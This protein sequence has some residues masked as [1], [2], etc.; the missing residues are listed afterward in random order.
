VL[1]ILCVVVLLLSSSYA[2]MTDY[3]Q[4]EDAIVFKTGNLE[5]TILNGEETFNLINLNNKLPESDQSGL[6]TATA[7]PITLKNTGSITIGTYDVKLVA[8]TGTENISTLSEEYI[9]FSVSEDNVTYSSPNTLIENENIIFTGNDL[10][11]DQTK[12]IYVKLWLSQ[13][14]NSTIFQQQYYGSIKIDSS[15]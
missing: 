8:E 11:K 5:M 14:A 6:D 4:K 15:Q 12:E 10:A 2:I 3:D 9:R 13:N 1:S 7:I